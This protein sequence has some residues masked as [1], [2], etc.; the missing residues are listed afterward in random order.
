MDVGPEEKGH[1]AELRIALHGLQGFH[2]LA[3]RVKPARELEVRFSGPRRLRLLETFDGLRATPHRREGATGRE[4]SAGI[5]RMSRF[6]LFGRHQ[7][8]RGPTEPQQQLR[9]ADEGLRGMAF[10]SRG[11]VVFDRFV[12]AFEILQKEGSV[13][14]Q[15]RVLG[16][17]VQGGA[18]ALQRLIVA[19]FGLEGVP[20][21]LQDLA[22]EH[23]RL[24]VFTVQDER[25]VQRVPR[26]LESA[27]T[28]QGLGLRHP[29]MVVVRIQLEALAD[30]LEAFLVPAEVVERVALRVQRVVEVRLDLEALVVV[31]QRLRVA[32]HLVQRIPDVVPRDLVFRVHLE[33]A[34]EVGDRFVVAA[35]VVERIA[36]VVPEDL[37]P[38]VQLDRLLVRGDGLLETVDPVE[39]VAFVVPG[40]LVRRVDREGLLVT[41]EGLVVDPEHEERE[42]LVV[43]RLLVVRV[44]RD[45]AVVG[46]DGLLV[47]LEGVQ[48]IAE[49][50][51]RVRVRRVRDRRGLV[52]GDGLLDLVQ[53]LQELAPLRP[54]DRVRSVRADER[55]VGLERGLRPAE[56]REHHGLVEQGV[57]IIRLDREGTVVRHERLVELA[58]LRVRVPEVV[59]RDLV[60]RVALHRARVRGDR[61]FVPA[62]AIEGDAA[63]VPH[64]VV[65]VT[66]RS[67][68]LV[69]GDGLRELAGVAM[70][71]PAEE[72]GLPPRQI[73]R[74][75]DRCQGDGKGEHHRAAHQERS[76]HKGSAVRL[77]DESHRT[78]FD[79]S[80]RQS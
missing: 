19:A 37:V 31:L 20:H 43:P 4:P 45:R 65:V 77:G 80:G 49:A 61:I 15:L 75:G 76:T 60:G 62:E 13:V 27:K 42:A 14:V 64:H 18:E 28:V 32:A 69:A 55:L 59:R 74:R 11:R 16:I 8:V 63:V 1:G 35:E 67:G 17:E 7:G 73:L 29:R 40:L 33:A 56:S 46:L 72:L 78:T 54:R 79:N 53:F 52:R 24:L 47:P 58:Q 36:E 38:P 44:R 2:V 41:R 25:V 71:V 48:G 9:Q 66:E 22:A 21:L 10:R 57:R 30:Q 26:L 3:G 23:P 70:D 39:R 50:R 51:P 68:A 34:L 12:D 6:G 5:R